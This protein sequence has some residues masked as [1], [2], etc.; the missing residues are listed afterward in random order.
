MTPNQEH[1]WMMAT[2]SRM[3]YG[4]GGQ[5]SNFSTNELDQISD[6]PTTRE[7]SSLITVSFQSQSHNLPTEVQFLHQEHKVSGLSPGC[8]YGILLKTATGRRHT[9]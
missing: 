4:P 8:T 9:R 6:G 1:I 3:F 2:I 5:E 7:L